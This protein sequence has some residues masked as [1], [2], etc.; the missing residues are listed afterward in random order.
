MTDPYKVLG[1]ERG[2]SD[3]DIKKAYR[4]LS[5]KYHPDANINNPNKAQIEEKFKEVQ[6]AYERIMKEKEYGSSYNDSGYG[7]GS[8]YGGG[9]NYGYGSQYDGDRQKSTGD[10]FED[11]FRA[12]GFGGFRGGQTS[13]KD[14][15]ETTMRINAAANYINSGHYKEALNVLNSISER[16]AK[17]Y[18]YSAIAN[19][20]TGN[21]V[22]ALEH[23]RK[24]Q[25]MEPSNAEYSNLAQ[26]L[27]SGESWYANRQADFGFGGLSGGRSDVCLRV[28][29]PVMVCSMCTGGGGL[30]FGRY[31]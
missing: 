29:L 13:Q 7:P 17:W 19:S 15:D 31:Y 8:S 27:A 5:R 1:I 25:Q 16:D 2:A 22:V 20:A 18:Y 6:Q 28:C 12:F 30:C 11:F 9:Y 24:A 3:D 21:N 23:A 10:P 4:A 14:M 26:R